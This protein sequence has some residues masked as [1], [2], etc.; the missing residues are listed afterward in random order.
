MLEKLT[1]EY[2]IHGKKIEI[3]RFH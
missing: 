1:P 2:N 3:P